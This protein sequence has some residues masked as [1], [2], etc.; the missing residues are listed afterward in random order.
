MTTTSLSFLIRDGLE[1]DIP[2]CLQLDHHYETNLVWQMT[3]DE[4]PGHWQIGFLN[5][6]LP[7]TLETEYYPSPERLRLGRPSDQCF[8]VAVTREANEPLGYL[9]MRNDPIYSI[10]RIH[11][12]VVSL[13]YRRQHIGTR[14]LSIARQWAK[15]HGLT[16]LMIEVATQNYPGIVFAQQSGFRFC[17]YNDHYF[18]NQDIAVFF[19]QS[20]T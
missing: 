16:S 6:H 17:G 10:A 2:A 18:A 3:V 13:P 19:S 12:L 5:Q 20:L 15:E 1:S 14:L 11:D 7:R 9:T 8:L 4:K